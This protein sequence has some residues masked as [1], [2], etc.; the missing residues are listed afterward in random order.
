[1]EFEVGQAVRCIVDAVWRDQFGAPGA[2]PRLGERCTISEVGVLP[3]KDE[4]TLS[5]GFAEYPGRW[6]FHADYFRPEGDAEMERLR[7]T[8]ASPPVRARE[9][10]GLLA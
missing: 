7:E 9:L 4:P 8:A 1:M 10:A 5:L 2:G 6:L 3:W